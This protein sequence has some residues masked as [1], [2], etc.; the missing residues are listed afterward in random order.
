MHANTSILKLS[1]RNQGFTTIHEST[2]CQNIVLHP[3]TKHTDVFPGR[4]CNVFG[5]FLP[6]GAPP[7]PREAFDGFAPFQDR[8]SFEFAE[9]IF[10]KMLC[11]RD[12]IDQLL[13]IWSAKNIVDNT[14]TDPVFDAHQ[15]M[16]NTIDAILWGDAPW[17]SFK[18]HWNG[19]ITPTSPAWKRAEYVV[20]A[21]N[22]LQV[23]EN[24]LDDGEFA[25]KFHPSAYQEFTTIGGRRYSHF[26]SGQWAW[27]E[28]VCGVV[29]VPPS[30]PGVNA[31]NLF[32]G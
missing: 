17:Y 2:V 6:Q 26:M 1:L 25:K 9:L 28:S 8:P 29:Y 18:I 30:V 21:Q 12:D 14:G 24:M 19:P 32:A 16:L 4:P 11:S 10:E 20:H 13:R 23:F 27:K 22:P 3:C 15:D 7:P 5:A 31:D